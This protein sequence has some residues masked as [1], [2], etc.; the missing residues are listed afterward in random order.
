L[1][2]T[3]ADVLQLPIAVHPSQQGPA[4]GAA[5]LGG[6]ASGRFTDIGEAVATMAQPATA[7]LVVEPRVEA[8]GRADDLFARYQ[9]MT[10][11]SLADR[12]LARQE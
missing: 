5:V 1:M 4:V 9:L 2:Q 6:L 7:G 8:K 12:A 10:E 11:L 3:F